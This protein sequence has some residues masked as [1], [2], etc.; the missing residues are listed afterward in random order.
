MG[1]SIHFSFTQTSVHLTLL[2]LS[3]EGRHVSL[4]LYVCLTLIW[5]WYGE[6]WFYSVPRPQHREPIPENTSRMWLSGRE[7]ACNAGDT[8]YVGSVPGLVG[9]PGRGNGKPLQYS[10][11][12]NPMDRGA[13]RA[14]VCGVTEEWTCLGDLS[15]HARWDKNRKTLEVTP[16]N[17][18]QEKTRCRGHFWLVVVSDAFHRGDKKSTT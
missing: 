3:M 6:D 11:W 7:S 1:P 2:P 13:W 17:Q 14:A 5:S 9:F 4:K 8:R 10:C 18:M 15:I 16:R 12:E